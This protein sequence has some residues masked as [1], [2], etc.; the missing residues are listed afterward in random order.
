[1]YY[2]SGRPKSFASISI[3]KRDIIIEFN[4]F[5][6]NNCKFQSMKKKSG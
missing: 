2:T 4:Q 6:K 1:M 3:I 5:N